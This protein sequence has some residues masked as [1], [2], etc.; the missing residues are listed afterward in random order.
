MKPSEIIDRAGKDLPPPP[1]KVGNIKFHIEVL[2][3]NRGE[4]QCLKPMRRKLLHGDGVILFERIYF[5]LSFRSAFFGLFAGLPSLF[6]RSSNRLRMLIGFMY[7]NNGFCQQSLC[8]IL[9]VNL[10]PFLS[11]WSFAYHLFALRGKYSWRE[12]PPEQ[13]KSTLILRFHF[14]LLAGNPQELFQ[15]S[16]V[17]MVLPLQ[18]GLL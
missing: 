1:D 14:C 2:R 11:A 5:H 17:K 16:P 4:I 9:T 18:Q 13:S 8:F 6:R 15:S 3:Q 10:S 12:F 7:P